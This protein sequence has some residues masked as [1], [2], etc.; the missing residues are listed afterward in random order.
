MLK[1]AHDHA[2]ALD[3][4]L[5]DLGYD[6]EDEPEEGD[7]KPD[8]D[9]AKADAATDLQKRAAEQQAIVEEVAKA[10]GLELAEPTQDAL[11][12]AALT[13]LLTLRKAHADLLAS[14]AAP[15]GVVNFAAV[16]KVADLA[17]KESKEPA[18]VVKSDGAVDDVATL[19]KA[20]QT[21]PIRLA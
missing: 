20:A 10:A 9:K 17:G 13:E 19:I 1:A 21:R 15:K 18:P 16:S 7:E 2:R 12:K 6:K 4:A 11:T 3:K 8:D 14:P 5:A